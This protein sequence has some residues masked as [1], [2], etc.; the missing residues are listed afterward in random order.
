MMETYG[1]GAQKTDSSP[2]LLYTYSYIFWAEFVT[3]KA[4]KGVNGT[5]TR[6]YLFYLLINKYATVFYHTVIK[7]N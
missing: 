6:V 3:N 5:T 2:M 4:N 7:K 1:C